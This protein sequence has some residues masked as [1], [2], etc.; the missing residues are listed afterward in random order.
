MAKP[1]FV[2]EGSSTPVQ[3]NR[4][5]LEMAPL[6]NCTNTEIY[7]AKQN[8]M[9]PE[10]YFNLVQVLLQIQ[11]LKISVEMPSKECG[12]SEDLKY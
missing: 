11:T 1:L 4:D 5:C 6:Y 12:S 2:V 7:S 10:L 8:N 9:F 3:T